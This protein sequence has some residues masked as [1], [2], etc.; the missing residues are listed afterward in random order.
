MTER[1]GD[2]QV[3][4]TI[5]ERGDA[6]RPI[7][8]RPED[9]DLF[10][11]SGKQ[12]VAACRSQVSVEL[13][14]QEANSMVQNVAK[15]AE[16]HSDKISACYVAN[17]PTGPAFYFVRR[18]EGF[19]FDLA[20]ILVDLNTNLVK[21]FNVGMVSVHQI[22]ATDAQRLFRSDNLPGQVYGTDPTVDTHR[23]VE[24]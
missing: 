8:L 4:L 12:V 18:T 17:T 24:A 20:D 10:F 2:S 13:W 5:D 1:K 11:R 19:D 15:W 3:K 9:N 6:D 16:E 7:L 22:A 14:I 21:N 23:A